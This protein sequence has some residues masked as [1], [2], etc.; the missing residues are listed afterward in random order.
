M[1]E[2]YL[3]RHAETIMNGEK[4][5]SGL[6][7]CDLSENG[8]RQIEELS[9][10]MKAYN[11]DEC[12]CS[13]LKRT[14]ITAGAFWKEPIIVD[15][16]HEMDFGD[17][18]GM[19]FTDVAEKYPKFARALL[20]SDDL[21][22]PNGESQKSMRQR[23]KRVYDEILAKDKNSSIAIVSHS[24]IIRAIVSKEVLGDYELSWSMNVDNCSIT[25]LEVYENNTILGFLNR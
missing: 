18:D 5:Y 23:A 7:D 4:R 9:E 20:K 11:I 2:V 10:K 14:R 6:L 1:K 22:F 12:Y 25:K 13:P 21:Q 16:L 8:Y 3:I 17:I 19:R 24:C 15:D